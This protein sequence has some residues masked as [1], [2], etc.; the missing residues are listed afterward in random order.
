MLAC[1][2]DYIGLKACGDTQPD[3]G[4]WINSLP[5][6]S[7][8]ALSATVESEQVNYKGLWSDIQ[9]EAYNQFYNDFLMELNNCYQLKPYCDYTGIICDNLDLITTPWKYLLGIYV[10]TFRL[11]TP[12]LN[13]FTTVDRAQAQEWITQYQ[14]AYEKSLTTAA[15]LLKLDHT[16]CCI[17]CGGNP[18]YVVWIP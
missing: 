17:Q 1:L 10:M 8:T 14:G 3:S 15:K 7:L 9:V 6:I 5:G 4:Q 2:L 13:S 12:R 16:D 11:Q 18:E